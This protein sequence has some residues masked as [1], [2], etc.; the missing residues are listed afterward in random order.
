MS[1]G[2]RGLF[3]IALS[4]L[5]ACTERFDI[6]GEEEQY[7]AYGQ[8]WRYSTIE[9][10]SKEWELFTTH[11]YIGQVDRIQQDVFLEPIRNER[12]P[13]HDRLF[14]LQKDGTYRKINCCTEFSTLANVY[15]ANDKLFVF[16][17]QRKRNVTDC[18]AHPAYQPDNEQLPQEKQISWINFYG[19]FDPE[20][21]VFYVSSFYPGIDS[22]T[23]E[24]MNWKEW[25][26]KASIKEVSKFEYQNRAPFDCKR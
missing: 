5:T 2:K 24:K 12:I 18:F 7:H 17:L 13:V 1:G 20:K 14:A 22:A 11:G 4:A 8:V 15:S 26:G 6:P 19:E 10:R 9:H 21:K 16:F 23:K 25:L 3:L